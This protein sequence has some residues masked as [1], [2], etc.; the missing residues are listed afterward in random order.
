[1]N[2][3]LGDYLRKLRGEVPIR[4]VA[5]ELQ[6]DQSSW[7]KYER[8]ERFPPETMF[9]AIAEYFNIDIQELRTRYLSDKIVYEIIQEENAEELLQVAE[10]KI[11]YIKSKSYQQAPLF[12]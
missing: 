10:E 11:R 3:S 9:L 8:G 2:E 1:M 5:S 6:A 4:V 12:K 7:S